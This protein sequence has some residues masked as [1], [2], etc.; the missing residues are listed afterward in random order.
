MKGTPNPLSR[1]QRPLFQTFEEDEMN[2]IFRDHLT[3]IFGGIA[4]FLGLLAV[5]GQTKWGK[6]LAKTGLV[7][8]ITYPCV[9]AALFLG[10]KHMGE[11]YAYLIF[12][13]VVAILLGIITGIV[14][15]VWIPVYFVRPKR[16]RDI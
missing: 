9:I 7:L 8:A 15:A 6:R 14:V 12:G 3:F 2:Q 16:N 11:S 1:I 13:D 10:R 4:A 5:P